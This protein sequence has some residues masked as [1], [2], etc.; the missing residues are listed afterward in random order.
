MKS[1]PFRKS[2]LIFCILNIYIIIAWHDWRYGASYSTRALMHSYPVFALSLGAFLN[3]F[4]L[5]KWRYLLWSA[6]LYLIAVNLFQI[7][8]Y[9]GT[10]LHFSDMNRRYYAGI[11]LDRNP[12][13]LDMSLLD[14]DEF[15]NNDD[16]YTEVILVD[17]QPAI[18]LD[19]PDDY[20]KC[21]LFRADIGKFDLP[22]KERWIKAEVSVF[23]ESGI[24]ESY[25]ILELQRYDSIKSSKI[26]M[27]NPISKEKA[28]NDYCFYI[29]IPEGFTEGYIVLNIQ[30]NKNFKGHV[31]KMRIVLLWR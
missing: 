15:I 16:R 17:S 20:A 12:T 24:W 30:T 28:I 5:T 11:Y 1:F 3:R 6:G 27:N 14:T 31:D 10:I 2:V 23:V 26:R 21:G 25:L 7:H 22:M 29:K 8:Q 18:I 9:N 19:S 4:L 13:P